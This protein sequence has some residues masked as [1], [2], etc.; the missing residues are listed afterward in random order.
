MYREA[1]WW[2]RKRTYN[3]RIQEELLHDILK[4]MSQGK[5]GIKPGTGGS[6]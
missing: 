2:R 3:L 4:E 5:I 6:T 1:R